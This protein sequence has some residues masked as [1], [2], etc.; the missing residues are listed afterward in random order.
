MLTAVP[1]VASSILG[2]F[3]TLV[4]V[5]HEIIY[6]VILL[7]QQIQKSCCSVTCER[8][9]N[10]LVQLAKENVWLDEL[11]T[12]MIIAVGLD[13][14]NQNNQNTT[15]RM[16]TGCQQPPKT[17][18]NGCKDCD[19]LCVGALVKVC[20]SCFRS[21]ENIWYSPAAIIRNTEIGNIIL[22]H[23]FFRTL[24]SNLDLEY[25]A[26]SGENCFKNLLPLP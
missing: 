1:G 2:R 13:I 8:L 18:E 20:M 9:V 7:L 26:V 15:F 16:A 24:S 23:A 12:R 14:K 5:D 17:H 22:L 11:S 3:Q 25:P 6:S 10:R 21:D 19:L 4:E